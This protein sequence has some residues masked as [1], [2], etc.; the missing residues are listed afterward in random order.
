M[1][2]STVEPKAGD[3]CPACGGE[4]RAAR[5]LTPDEYAEFTDQREPRHFP[6]YVDTAAPKFVAKFGPLAK[7]RECG[8]ETRFKPS[9]AS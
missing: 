9:D 5:A 4:F 1:D 7:C 8:Y 3:P 2:K 6:G